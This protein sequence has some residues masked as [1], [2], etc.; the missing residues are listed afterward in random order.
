MEGLVGTLELSSMPKPLRISFT[1]HDAGQCSCTC[2]PH[3]CY[4]CKQQCWKEGYHERPQQCKC[5]CP[6]YSCEHCQPE[7]T[8]VTESKE[9]PHQQPQQIQCLCRCHM[10]YCRYCQQECRNK[11]IDHYKP[12]QCDFT[13]RCHSCRNCKQQCNDTSQY[14]HSCR[15]CHRTCYYNRE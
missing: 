11:T 14:G 15:N 9:T 3:T 7:V 8:E 2:H 5:N 6:P 10:H 13:C 4:M 1:Q 12:Q